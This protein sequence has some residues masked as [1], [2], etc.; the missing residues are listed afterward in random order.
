[1]RGKRYNVSTFRMFLKTLRAR[2]MKYI[3]H[4]M[5]S[6]WDKLTAAEK[7]KYDIAKTI[8]DYA[9]LSMDCNIYF[10]GL[11][12][13]FFNNLV[14]YNSSIRNTVNMNEFLN[15]I[16]T[17]TNGKLL[18]I[19]DIAGNN[20]DVMYNNE[21]LSSSTCLAN[22]VL[23]M[24]NDKELKLTSVSTDCPYISFGK[25]YSITDMASKEDT[26][27]CEYGFN[28][29]DTMQELIDAGNNLYHIYFKFGI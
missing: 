25:C 3:W 15:S 24:F 19:H 1:M 7:N 6:E 29:P 26:Y 4:G 10:T 5:Q 18:S 14:S 23:Q 27:I 21:G 12:E 17:V 28:K 22:T 9:E 16:F 11:T 13:E 2:G 8:L 20:A